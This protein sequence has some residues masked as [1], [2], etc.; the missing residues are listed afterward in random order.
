VNKTPS[1][2]S[3]IAIRLTDVTQASTLA[4]NWNS[5]GQDKVQSWDQVHDG[6]LSVFSM[7]DTMRFCIIAAILVVAGFGIYNIL[8]M[9]VHHKRREIAILRSIGYEPH[10]IVNLFFLQGV[11]LGAVGGAVGLG[12]G[13]LLSLYLETI[14]MA[15]GSGHALGKGTMMI[16]YDPNIYFWAWVLAFIAASFASILPAR[17]AGKMTPIDIIRSEE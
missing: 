16:S 10:D 6:I 17:A 1:Q 5:L 7:Q 9:A 11:I 14:R 3:N 2:I 15:G 12:V 8:S 13:Y 4:D